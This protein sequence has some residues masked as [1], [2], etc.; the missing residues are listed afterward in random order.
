M[1]RS[2]LGMWKGYHLSPEGKQKGYV[3]CLK[4]Y[5]QR[6]KGWS[7]GQS[8]FGEYPPPPPLW[9]TV[10]LVWFF[11]LISSI[12]CFIKWIKNPDMLKEIMSP[13]GEIKSG[14]MVSKIYCVIWHALS[15]R[16]VETIHIQLRVFTEEH[17]G[18]PI[19]YLPSLVWDLRL[20]IFKT[21]DSLFE[22]LSTT[23]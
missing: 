15:K 9:V 1:Q 11:S 19:F 8:L 7:L 12:L 13:G 4:W 18:T 22:G 2:K 21:T 5:I 14:K 10:T 17:I 23:F 6:V 3:F 16:N 20:F